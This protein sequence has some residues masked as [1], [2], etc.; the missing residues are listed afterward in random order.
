MTLHTFPILTKIAHL[1][2]GH[3]VIPTNGEMNCIFVSRLVLMSYQLAKKRLTTFTAKVP[4]K[5]PENIPHLGLWNMISSLPQPTPSCQRYPTYI[6]DA[7]HML[8]MSLYLIQQ[9][10]KAGGHDR[11]WDKVTCASI[12]QLQYGEAFKKLSMWYQ[13]HLTLQQHCNNSYQNHTPGWH[14]KSTYVQS[15]YTLLVQ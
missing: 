1:K 8:L 15:M 12:D 3:Q 6:H 13:I 2:Q 11:S 7:K 4:G 14:N 10:N 9:S 5:H